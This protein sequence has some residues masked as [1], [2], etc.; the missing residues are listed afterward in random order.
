MKGLKSFN[1]K[2]AIKTGTSVLVGGI[3]S[4]IADW[5]LAKYDIIPADYQQYTNAG[6]VVVGAIAGSMV[7]NDIVK[8]AFDGI[9]TV[10]AA[11]LVKG[12]LPD[13]AAEPA[14]ETDPVTGLPKG[15]IGAARRHLGQRG[16]ARKMTGVGSTPAALMSK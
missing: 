2:S 14:I 6:K 15:M 7:K 3:G 1:T 9:A 8:S 16:F 12:F 11:E 10:G 13:A 4:A 5:L